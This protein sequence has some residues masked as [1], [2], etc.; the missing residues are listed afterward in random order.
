[1]D[2][3]VRFPAR[4]KQLL[5]RGDISKVSKI[6]EPIR[7]GDEYIIP[8]SSPTWTN[9]LRLE[10]TRHVLD[11]PKYY[12]EMSRNPEEAR[13][14][15][16]EEQ[17]HDEEGEGEND[18]LAAILGRDSLL[19]LH[20]PA[21]TDEKQPLLPFMAILGVSFERVGLGQRTD[22][23]IFSKD[24]LVK[25]V[26]TTT[27][28]IGIVDLR[29]RDQGALFVKPEAFYG[30][31]TILVYL[32][33]QQVGILMDP[34]GEPSIE[35]KNIPASLETAWNNAMVVKRQLIRI[36]MANERPP[37]V[38]AAPK[39]KLLRIP[40]QNNEEPEP[41]KPKREL[42]IPMNNDEKPS[43]P[44]PKLR[45]SMANQIP[46]VANRTLRRVRF[47][48]EEGKSRTQSKTFVTEEPVSAIKRNQT[49]RKIRSN[50]FE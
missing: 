40:M 38:A 7:Q 25:Y 14:E 27:K 35:L 28:P 30:A 48:N 13:E 32:P 45:I 36:P 39:K 20:I 9:L 15:Y 23:S 24:N 3:L 29:A 12:E 4:R 17:K 43:A 2:E 16:K 19:R 41:I 34:N 6:M 10:W 26:R 46:V 47:A 49:K 37:L 50:L 11:E 1:L 44:K 21:I 18:E 22:A 5:T 42:R 8:E 31:V 33:N